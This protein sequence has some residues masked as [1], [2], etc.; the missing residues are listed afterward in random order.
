[1][2]DQRV[3]VVGAGVAGLVS[4]L[5]LSHLGL[6]V[7]VIDRADAPGGKLHAE[8]VDGHA[9][10]SGP[11]VFTMRWVFDELM[12]SLDLRL[13]RELTLTPLSV[14]ARHFWTDGSSLDLFADPLASE[15]AV[16]AFAGA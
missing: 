2:P 10:D 3:V 13:D 15:S 16:E 11:T 6:N 12:H 1:M 8:T 14:L 9:I 5:E 4:A 7:T